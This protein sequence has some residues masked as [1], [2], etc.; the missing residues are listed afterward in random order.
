MGEGYRNS[1]ENDCKEKP[2]NDRQ[3]NYDDCHK[4]ARADSSKQNKMKQ[5]GKN[6]EPNQAQKVAHPLL[7]YTRLSAC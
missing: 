3:T 6:L 1:C 4:T 2:C 5:H 7:T